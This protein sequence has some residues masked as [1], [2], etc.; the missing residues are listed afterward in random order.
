MS[1]KKKQIKTGSERWACECGYSSDDYHDF[2]EH[3][4]NI[5]S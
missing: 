5:E 1:D 4:C 3:E 2:E